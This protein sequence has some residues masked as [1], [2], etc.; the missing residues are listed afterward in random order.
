MAKSKR[1][2]LIRGLVVIPA[3]SA[4]L[5]GA[6]VARRGPALE[7]AA[8]EMEAVAARERP[9]LAA[10]KLADVETRLPVR[11]RTKLALYAEDKDTESALRRLA[12]MVDQHPEIMDAACGDSRLMFEEAAAIADEKERLTLWYE[13][14][15]MQRAGMF[16][17]GAE[18]A[19]DSGRVVQ[20]RILAHGIWAYVDDTWQGVFPAEMK[21]IRALASAE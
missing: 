10:A 16:A 5:W 8:E 1:S 4:L 14:C 13:R 3:V 15:D 2:G 21:L 12:I 20:D 6:H 18:M 11:F 9:F 19:H 17:S 7:R